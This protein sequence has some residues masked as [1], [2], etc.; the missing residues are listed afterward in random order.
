[1]PTFSHVPIL[2]RYSS[3]CNAMP[4]MHLFLPVHLFFIS[5]F[6][7]MPTNSQQVFYNPPVFSELKPKINF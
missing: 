1:M 5:C 7:E 6:L 2:A 4:C 3:A